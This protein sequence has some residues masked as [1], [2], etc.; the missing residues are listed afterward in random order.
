MEFGYEE[1]WD[2]PIPE[3]Y[4]S[5]VR[6]T[7]RVAMHQALKPVSASEVE[8]VSLDQLDGQGAE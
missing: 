1:D 6:F 5:A 8:P 4:L 2:W 3:K 7:G